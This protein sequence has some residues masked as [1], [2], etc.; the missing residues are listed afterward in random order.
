[1][2]KPM[3]MLAVILISSALDGIPAFGQ[4][5]RTTA[6]SQAQNGKVAPLASKGINGWGNVKWGMTVG[7]ATAVIPNT[8]TV[9]N[10]TMKVRV[11]QCSNWCGNEVVPS[12]PVKSVILQVDTL[13]LE[14]D[15]QSTFD[16]LK[17]ALI[18]KY[19]TPSVESREGTDVGPFNERTA[20][21][22]L[23][24]TTIVLNRQVDRHIPID[25][26]SI[27]YKPYDSDVL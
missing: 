27:M 22:T 8:V 19:G 24:S 15:P 13:K 11:S 1:M 16:N 4:T 12:L 23:P 2:I 14:H 6:P 18:R 20:I 9:E 26:V 3:S 5:Q 17:T 21:W 10:V 7:E 25:S